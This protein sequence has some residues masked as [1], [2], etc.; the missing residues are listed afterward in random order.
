[1]RLA[2]A[3]LALDPFSEG[4]AR[5][6]IERLVEA[7][8]RAGAL[9]A[10][11]DLRERLRT[12]LAI[13]PSAATRARYDSIRQRAPQ[14]PA[15]SPLLDRRTAGVFVGRDADRA[16]AA[17][18]RGLN[19]RHVALWDSDHVHERLAV[20][21]EMIA[22]A[23]RAGDREA[24]LQGRYWRVVDLFELGRIGAW[25]EQVSD[26]AAMAE[27][28]RLPTYGWYTPLRH[29]VRATAGSPSPAAPVPHSPVPTARRN[30]RTRRWTD[31]H[32]S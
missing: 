5:D 26:H 15:S 12:A 6:L 7:G 27:A 31:G 14:R 2:R 9:V 25:W 29:S 30:V 32:G 16:R 10:Y 8:D 18:E 1:M 11:D 28:L 24:A 20:A 21:E 13:A 22:V 3:R 17:G 19:A 4:A 23:E